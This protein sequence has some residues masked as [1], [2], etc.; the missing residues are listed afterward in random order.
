MKKASVSEYTY[1]MKSININQIKEVLAAVLPAYPVDF[2]YV[3]GS[4]ARGKTHAESDLDIALG[5]AESVRDADEDVIFKVMPMVS[6]KLEVPSEK[7]DIQDFNHLPLPVRFR[8]IRD[9]KLVYFKNLARQ[10]Q[11]AL[12]TI[13]L[14]HDE[15]PFLEK[16]YQ[17]FL[18][19]ATS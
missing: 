13:S 3:Y 18:K 1:G 12:Q 17:A 11:L 15:K 9:G 19:R 16:S 6:R 4:R 14:Y 2:A 8:V 10:R 5:L 7:L